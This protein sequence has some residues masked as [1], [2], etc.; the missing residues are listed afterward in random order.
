MT[1]NIHRHPADR[2]PAHDDAPNRANGHARKRKRPAAAAPAVPEDPRR[3][4]GRALRTSCPRSKHAITIV[5]EQ[6]KA[7][8]PLALIERSNQGRVPSLLP[9]RFSRM[10]E[11]PFAFFRGTAIVQAHDLKGTPSPGIIVQCCGDC[12]L[13]NFGVFASPERTLLFDIN[14][15]DETSPAPFEWDLKRLA[16][17][18]V[19]AARWRDFDKRAA[20][21][22]VA[23]A[24]SSYRRQ[25]AQFATMSALDVW[26]ARIT[27]DDLMKRVA[28][29]AEIS[30]RLARMVAKAN[31]NT[32]EAVFH[33]MTHEVH[34]HPR[35]VDQPP[36]VYHS[37]PAELDLHKDLS[38]FFEA[39]R[40]TISADRRVLFN[41]Y[42]LTD[43]AFKVV[44][45]GSV[46]TICFVA[47][48]MSDDHDPLFLQ[49]KQ[50]RPSVLEE[51]A[52]PSGHAND[53]ER[54]VIGQRIMQSA[55]DIFLGWANGPRGENFYVRQLRDHKVAPD[56]ST[57]TDN[58][59]IAYATVCGQTLARAHAKS[60]KAAQISG[61]LGAADNFDDALTDYAVAYAD[62]VEADY[63]A[64]RAA[65]K[66]GRFPTETTRSEM[67]TAIR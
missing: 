51:T 63:H 62:Q 22:A 46:G 8:D 14:D 5:P 15:F 11:S 44:G 26:Y 3:A 56:I 27:V 9:V 53:G 49:V 57:V 60:G 45:V 21:K 40:A 33:K 52:G 54:V 10:L 59:L 25:I 32:G 24:A 30:G 7:R 47:L 50:A 67:E 6:A 17:S 37:D 28:K 23:A 48:F 41:R 42:Q 39:Y 20:R 2:K 12:H 38:D 43:A 16:A 36:L 66:A 61:Y 35:I 65:A 34:G 64:F 31:A 58:I 4:E 29:D 1:V 55:S 18:F 13:L 19:M